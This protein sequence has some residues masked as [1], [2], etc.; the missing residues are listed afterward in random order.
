[1]SEQQANIVD[2]TDASALEMRGTFEQAL[3][4]QT[5]GKNGQ[6]EKQE[7]VIKTPYGSLAFEF[8]GYAI[9]NNI[10][11]YAVGEDVVVQFQINQREWKGRT[12]TRLSGKSM[13]RAYQGLEPEESEDDAPMPF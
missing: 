6:Y 12:Y 5:V 9:P 8:F 7:I 10:D 11:D 1:M 13:R 3:D 2:I 4:R